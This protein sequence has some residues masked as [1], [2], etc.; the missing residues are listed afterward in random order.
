ME[1]TKQHISLETAK[2]LK[3]CGIDSKYCFDEKR[4]A[5]F[6]S[7]TRTGNIKVKYYPAFTWQ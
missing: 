4:N 6:E 5:V 3:D 2:L 1:A 7:S